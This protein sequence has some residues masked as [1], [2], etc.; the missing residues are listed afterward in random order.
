MYVRGAP[1]IGEG[2]GDRLIFS[3]SNI[4]AK[5]LDDRAIGPSNRWTIDMH[6]ISVYQLF[7]VCYCKCSLSLSLSLSLSVLKKSDEKYNYVGC[8][9]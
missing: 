5:V 4:N 2:S 6:S 7:P 9:C 3:Q 8:I 1:C